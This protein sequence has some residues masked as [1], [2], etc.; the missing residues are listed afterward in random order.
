MCAGCPVRDRTPPGAPR[1]DEHVLA[2]VLGGA[3]VADH[4]QREPVDERRELVVDL[5][6]RGVRPR[7][8]AARAPRAPSRSDGRR[9][10]AG[11][12]SAGTRHLETHRH[13]IRRGCPCRGSS[14]D[15]AYLHGRLGTEAGQHHRGPE[16]R[17]HQQPR[18]GL[19][20]P[21]RVGGR[22]P[23]RRPRPPPTAGRRSLIAS[24]GLLRVTSATTAG[25][26]GRRSATN[27]GNTDEERPAGGGDAL[28]ARGTG[29]RPASSGPAITAVP[30]A[31]AAGVTDR[32][33]DEPGERAL[34]RVEHDHERRPTSCPGRASR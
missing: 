5:A 2:H 30:A 25:E 16:H 32:Q 13:A 26:D 22:R 9:G 20:P 27:G 8:P 34:G 7:R 4:P 10:G 12:R 19:R 21:P 3:G 15:D 24:D 1:T 33:A 28:A 31:Y 14:Q 17:V 11:R 29:S 6:E 23:T 18:G